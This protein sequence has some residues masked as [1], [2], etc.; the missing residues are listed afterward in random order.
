MPD[1]RGAAEDDARSSVEFP[2]HKVK[3]EVKR[4]TDGQHTISIVLDGGKAV[5]VANLSFTGLLDL[6]VLCN[7]AILVALKDKQR[8]A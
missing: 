2:V 8:G 6:M 7:E 5:Y 3:L 1:P 4:W